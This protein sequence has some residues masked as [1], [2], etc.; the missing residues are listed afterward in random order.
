MIPICKR[1][2]IQYL[3]ASKVDVVSGCITGENCY[4]KEKA[5]RLESTYK[6]RNID[7]FYADSSSDLPLANIAKEAFLV[8]KVKLLNGAEK[9][10]YE[11]I[12]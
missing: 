6:I 12:I 3:I 9:T 8:K 7:K 2:G 5:N 1:L 10:I 11:R 4:G